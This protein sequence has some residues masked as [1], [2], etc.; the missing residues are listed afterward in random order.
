MKTWSEA[1]QKLLTGW[2]DLVQRTEGTSRAVVW[3][4]IVT[5]WQTAVQE[6]LD[7]QAEWLCDW[8]KR[9]QAES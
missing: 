5:A 9:L 2:L 1:Q 8:S 6:T 7:T 4:E 3:N